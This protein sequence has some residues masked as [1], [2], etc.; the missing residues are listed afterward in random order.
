MKVL[1]VGGHAE[2][3]LNFRGPLI[4]AL[5]GRGVVV[6]VAA[7]GLRDSSRLRALLEQRGVAAG[8]SIL[9]Q[10]TGMGPLADILGLIGLWRLIRRVRPNLVLA[11]TVKPVIYGLLAARFAGVSRRMALITGLGY[12]FI[13]QSPSRRAL[14]KLVGV[15]YRIA[16][17]G[18]ERVFFQ[19]QDDCRLFQT[20][21]LVRPGQSEVVNGSGVDLVHFAPSTPPP[22]CEPFEFLLIARLLADKGIREYVEA[23]RL[24][25]QRHPSTRFALVGPPDSNPAAIGVDEVAKWH[26][27]GVIEYLGPLED[28]RPALQR[29]LVYVLPSYR[30]GMPRTV[31][32]AMAMCRPIITADVPGCRETVVEGLNGYLVPPKDAEKLANAMLRFVRDPSLASR[33]GAASRKIAE[34]KYDVQR[35]NQQMLGAMGLL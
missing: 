20:L 30:E 18:A 15:L 27:E 4:S 17:L 7:P 25:K 10:R 21:K 6:H 19:N 23:A 3:L 22:A 9:L 12:A 11:Y 31:L 2:S 26:A 24:V 35:V 32:E 14:A 16:L 8:H 5:R 28:V 29:C 1:I 34:D 33:M 13:G